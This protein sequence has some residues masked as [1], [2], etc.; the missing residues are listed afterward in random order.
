MEV[1]SDNLRAGHEWSID[2]AQATSAQWIASAWSMAL[3]Y[4]GHPAEALIRCDAALDLPGGS[5]LTRHL[6]TA[7]ASLAAMRTGD[8]VRAWELALKTID[9]IEGSGVTPLLVW[10]V[11]ATA[12][13][14]AGSDAPGASLLEI[15]DEIRKYESETWGSRADHFLGRHLMREGKFEEALGVL[16]RSLNNDALNNWLL[17]DTLT[18]RWAVDAQSVKRDEIEEVMSRSSDDLLHIDARIFQLTVSKSSEIRSDS[19]DDILMLIHR[20][21]W[22]T[23]N[24]RRSLSVLAAVARKHAIGAVLWGGSE[25]AGTGAV[26][27]GCVKPEMRAA[28]GDPEFAR[29]ASRG[30]TMSEPELEEAVRSL[31][32][33]V[34]AAS[35]R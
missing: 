22:S 8:P 4:R 26:Y 31:A 17:F 28:L 20:S 19:I 15:I 3:E 30:A 34:S 10:T 32:T 35:S 7:S 9:S 33:P 14:L 16:E 21:G 11:A 5:S 24:F 2:V 23:S 13:E 6:C 1:E 25:R 27:Q 29:L 18:C 12:R